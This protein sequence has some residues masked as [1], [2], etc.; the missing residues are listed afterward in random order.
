MSGNLAKTHARLML[1]QAVYQQ[2]SAGAAGLAEVDEVQLVEAL[3]GGDF[4][5][6]FF[7]KTLK[8]V[9]Q[10]WDALR[11]RIAPLLE[12]SRSWEKLSAVQR[13]VLRC[14]AAEIL[15]D[16]KTPKAVVISQ[17]MQVAHSFYDEEEGNEVRFLHAVL[18]ELDG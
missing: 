10:E 15:H 8:L 2:D 1:V 5:K 6:R 14:G 7:R 12:E 3:D 11:G 17:Y 4:D 13:A 9:A 18:D 16:E